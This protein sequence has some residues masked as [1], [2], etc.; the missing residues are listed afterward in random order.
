MKFLNSII[1]SIA[2]ILAAYLLGDAYLGRANPDGTIATTGLG[3]TDFVSDLTVWEADFVRVNPNLQKAFNDLARDK[4]IV[5]NYLLKKGVDEEHIV[6]EAVTTNEQRE[7]QYQNGNFTGTVFTGYELR[8]T[9]KVESKYVQ[10][11][12]MVSREITELLNEDIQLQSK[13]PRYY[14]TKLADLKIKM[15]SQAT[16]DARLRAQKIA[17]NGGGKLGNLKSAAMGVFQ[18]T[19][20]N[21]SEDYSWSGSFNTSDKNK[22]ASIT[23][24]LEYEID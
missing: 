15:I 23:M 5:R 12:E 2:I 16:A 24:R 4:E 14:Y 19:G 11:V 22:T 7:N 1:F 9:V 6:F 18:I 17:E 13:P 21:S 20:Q 10:K 8:Q 3:S